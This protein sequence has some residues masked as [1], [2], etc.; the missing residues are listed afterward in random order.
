[1]TPQSITQKGFRGTLQWLCRV[2]L[3]R[4]KVKVHRLL[5]VRL[6][7]R[8]MPLCLASRIQLPRRNGSKPSQ[9]R[10]SRAAIPKTTIPPSP[11]LESASQP[12]L[13]N[14]HPHPT[15]AKKNLPLLT[16][17]PPSLNHHQPSTTAT[18]P[19]SKRSVPS[20]TRS[21]TQ[22][23]ALHE[24]TICFANWAKRML[25]RMSRRLGHFI[26]GY[27]RT[28]QR[29]KE[30]CEMAENRGNIKSCLKPILVLSSRG[31]EIDWRSWS[32]GRIR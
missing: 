4:G 27:W 26:I 1:M 23:K 21:T 31:E 17:Q 14:P 22:T 25:T 18:A 30:L 24:S 5:L 10:P 2:T 6:G 16:T 12:S 7:R 3:A 9:R 15:P 29:V 28:Q 8:E 11:S 19:P 13:S 20:T 32:R